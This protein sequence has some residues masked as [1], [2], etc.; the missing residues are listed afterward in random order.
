MLVYM[1][2]FRV[3]HHPTYLASN[4]LGRK[5]DAKMVRG[6]REDMVIILDPA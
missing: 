1:Y 2:K 6:S 3:Y 4:W 5:N